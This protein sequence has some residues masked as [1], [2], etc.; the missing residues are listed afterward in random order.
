[1]SQKTVR[2]ALIALSNTLPDTRGTFGTKESTDPVRHLIGA[3]NAW[4][5]NPERTRSTSPSSRRE[6]TAAPCT[7]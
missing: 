4:G 5:G 1:V 7:G 3:A 2:D 6:T